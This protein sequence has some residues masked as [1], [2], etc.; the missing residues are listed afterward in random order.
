MKSKERRITL[1]EFKSLREKMKCFNLTEGYI[2]EV[3]KEITLFISECQKAN[4]KI[5]LKDIEDAIQTLESKGL[6]V[7]DK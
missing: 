6:E 2:G 3:G 1:T 7:Y 5:T 4:A